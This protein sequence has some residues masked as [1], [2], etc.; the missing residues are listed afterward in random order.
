MS[1]SFIFFNSKR[2][3]TV[4]LSS[5]CEF[6]GS[7]L[8]ALWHS[9]GLSD[10]EQEKEKLK[11]NDLI[12]ATITSFQA[13][14]SQTEE[15]LK[16]KIQTTSDAFQ[17][18]KKAFGIPCE[19][20]LTDL[21]ES[22]LRSHL[23]QIT[24]EYE[25]FKAS[26]QE[27]IEKFSSLQSEV[28]AL[29]S[30][31]EIPEED[32]GEFGKVDCDDY[33]VGRLQRF[34]ETSRLLQE[35]VQTRQEELTKRHSSIQELAG[36]LEVS[37]PDYVTIAFQASDISTETMKKV[38]ECE[39]NL[40]ATKQL[41]EAEI[42][43]RKTSLTRL[44]DALKVPQSE[45]QE[46]LAKQ[47]TIGETALDA[48]ANAI[49]RLKTQREEHLPEIIRAQLSEINRI[50][51]ELHRTLTQIVIE[52]QDANTVY[53]TLENVL[54]TLNAEYIELRPFV[55]MINQRTELLSEADELNEAAKKLEEARAKKKEIDQKKLNKDE[56]ARRRIRSLLPRLEKK[57]LL[58]L[59]EYQVNQE[60]D[61]LWDGQPYVEQ[62]GHIKLSDI[63]LRQ[64]KFTRKKSVSSSRRISQLG[65][66][67]D[68]AKKNS[69]RSLENRQAP[70]NRPN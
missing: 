7:S 61:F 16:C 28:S 52:G 41:R 42:N 9:I 23:S 24:S 3:I 66:V 8:I 65:P 26:H 13:P 50:E 51:S 70:L 56:Q 2:S 21:P 40:I 15:D 55:E 22:N 44:W 62:L 59:L 36:K 35:Q 6:D 33:T 18:L 67:E 27:C 46:F 48:Y 69:R 20:L 58:S 49:G 54:D 25:S 39:A 4:M 31:L 63:E 29:F 12:R 45:R 37:V 19:A 17:K 30:K 14:F 34:T 10:E 1:R 57:L 32:R 43:R 60:K 47:S 11:L 64:A 38:V 68:V 53:D 5:L